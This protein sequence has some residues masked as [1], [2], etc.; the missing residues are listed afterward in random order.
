MQFPK[1]LLIA[2]MF[3]LAPATS[4]ASLMGIGHLPDGTRSGAWAISAD[5]STVVGMATDSEF[6]EGQAIRW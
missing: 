5:G 3:S 4:A 1:S 6:I 2:A